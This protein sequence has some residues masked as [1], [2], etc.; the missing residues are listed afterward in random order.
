MID[1]QII[2]ILN[3]NARTPS[4]EISRTV[5][6]PERTV[7]N[8]IHRLV[9][10]G[11]IQAIA[12]VNPK[13]FGYTLAVDIFCEIEMGQIAQ[14]TEALKAMPEI[15]Y[16]AISTGDQD[17]SIQALFKDIEDMQDFITYKLHQV[18]GMHRSRTVLIPRIAKDTYQWLPP[19]EYFNS[20]ANQRSAIGK[21]IK[22]GQRAST[23]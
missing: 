9:D 5:G 10:G 7:H 4:A 12:V 20:N 6:I 17:L 16:I 19:E 21:V 1:R 8:R 14:A 22:A 3:Q 13:A 23:E 2:Q 11:F 15:S 18:P